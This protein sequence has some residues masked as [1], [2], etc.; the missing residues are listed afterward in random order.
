MCGEMAG[1]R[2]RSRKVGRDLFQGAVPVFVWT[3]LECPVLH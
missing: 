1:T 3:G 2:G